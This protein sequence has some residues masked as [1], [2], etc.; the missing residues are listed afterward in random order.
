MTTQRDFT[1]FLGNLQI[2]NAGSISKRYKS[3]TRRLNLHF[4]KLDC[5]KSNSL[6]A[7]SYGRYS[8]I[9]GIS[10][11][12]MLYIIP[13]DHWSDYKNDPSKLLDHCKQA[14]KQTYPKTEIIKDRNVVVVQFNDFV[15]EVVPVFKWKEKFKYPDTYG[16]GKWRE[17]DTKAELKSF[18]DK[19]SDRNGNLRRLAKMVRAWKR[20]N[21][22]TMSGFLIDTLCHQF[23]KDN[24]DYDKSSYGSYDQM[25]RDFFEFLAN[26]PERKYYHA[27]GSNSQVSVNKPFQ[28]V[29]ASALEHAESAIAAKAE[30]D[31]PKCNK[32]YK[33]IFGSKFPSL[34]QEEARVSTEEFIED[35]F[36]SDLTNI[37]EI[38]CEVRADMMTQLLSKLVINDDGDNRIRHRH[39]LHFHIA[40]HN[41]DGPFKLK[42]KVLNRGE[43][44]N[45]NN[46]H[47]GQ[48]IDDDGS[49]TRNETA[50]FYGDHLV[51]CYAI[52][53]NKVIA[54]DWLTVP[55]DIGNKTH[56]RADN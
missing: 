52:Q 41:I 51:E 35:L 47:R 36:D 18:K 40:D 23:F 38:E 39:K 32:K 26:E 24:T 28:G 5:K 45:R 14:I 37:I 17:C 11:L 34:E 29:A 33:A 43:I 56:D 8:G 2:K 49:K 16:D 15:F 3:I 13:E 54:R 20:K 6:Q 27:M 55:I 21:D 31:L 42:W 30:D 48:I 25:V 46:N 12:D 44:A 50:S 10:D 1:A 22:I 4:R 9:N 19:N 53:G 7:G